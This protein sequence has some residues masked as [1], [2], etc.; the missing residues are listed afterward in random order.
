MED[1]NLVTY[2]GTRLL[3]QA[4]EKTVWQ[5]ERY[6]YGLQLVISLLDGRR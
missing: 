4:Q 1:P 3:Q 2:Q 6:S 5:V